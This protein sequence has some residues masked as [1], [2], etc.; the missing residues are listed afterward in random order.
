MN[1]LLIATFSLALCAG[2]ISASAQNGQ[3][4]AQK[5]LV[6]QQQ[7]G[8]MTWSADNGNG[9][10]TNPLFYD[11]FSDPDIIRV[12]EDYYLA[13]TTMHS[14]PGLVVLHSKDLVN[15]EFSSY[16]FDR[17]DDSDDFNLRNGKEA[18]GQGIWAPAIRYHKGKFYIFSNINGHGLQVFISDSAKGPWKHHQIKGDIYDL[19][20]LFDDDGK[21]YAIHKYGNVTVT[22]LKPDLSGPVEGSSKVV[23]PE[24]NAMGEG[25]HIY[26]INGMYYILSADYSP[27]GRMQCAR[28]KSIWGPY[29]TC[30]IS[31]RE[32]FGYSAAWTVNNVGLGRPVPE[33]GFKFKNN[34]P[35]DETLI[36]STIHQGGIVQAPDGKWWGVSMQDFNAVGRTT[37]LSPVT[38]VDGWPYFGLEK[39]LGR[40]PRTWFKPN[41]VVKTPVATY[42]RCDD[43]SGKT[44]KPIWQWNHNPN[45][46]MWSLNKERK[47]WLRLHSMPAKQLLWAKNSLTQRAIGPVS[48]TS[49]KLDASKLKAGDEAGLGAI[50]MPY[51][52]L[53]VVKTD[54]GLALRCYDQNTNKEVVLPLDKKVVWLRLW[55]DYD[56][57]QLQYSYSLDGK[58]WENIGEQMISPYQLKTFQGVRGALYAFNKKDVNGGV[59]DFDDFKVEEPM[60][61]RTANLPIG[62]TVRFFN[63]AD[64]SLMDATRHGLM[65]SSRNRKNMS[66]GVKFVV[67]DR[68]QG[69]IALK[70]ADGRYVYI[71]G[72]GLSGDV[73]LTSD[74]SKAEEFVWQD[75]LYNH[76]MLLSLKTQRYV[77]KHTL[78][79]SPYSA[80]F[81]GADAGMKNGCVFAWEI[82]E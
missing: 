56:K 66:N 54:K 20:V 80:D 16:C 62:K 3:V 49:V 37:C 69:K 45:D 55:G 36:C 71:A 57:S 60:A 19:S 75:M 70:T 24:G 22:E 12:G 61:D 78:D 58:N 76:C 1:K 4:S 9:T 2:S 21:I 74:A 53:G 40:S 48:Y 41:N 10:Y 11:E 52:S 5:K 68:G 18:Y 28:S 17:F 38:W 6:T 43:F 47:G 82:V 59:A 7:P 44:F 51:A 27:M 33:D 73:R 46:K 72:A 39:N 63:L 30:V 42:D 50:N 34:K 64:G 81:Q 14:V 13:G 79:G 15:W 65:H 67:E 77:G 23:I 35:S 31:E 32:S 29:E 8:R 26:K 25:H